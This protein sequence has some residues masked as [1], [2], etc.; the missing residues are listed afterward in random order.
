MSSDLVISG[1]HKMD[2]YAHV[3]F[4]REIILNMELPTL[5]ELLDDVANNTLRTGWFVHELEIDYTSHRPVIWLH[6]TE[7]DTHRW[8]ALFTNLSYNTLAEHL[9][10]RYN[11]IIIGRKLIG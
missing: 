1:L 5:L 2:D 4:I 8:I 7:I 3:K 6:N 11:N 10:G 9:T